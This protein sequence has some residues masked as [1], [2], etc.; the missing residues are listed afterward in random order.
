MSKKK[1]EDWIVLDEIAKRDR[2]KALM[3][4]MRVVERDLIQLRK[5]DEVLTT[6][7][8]D[9]EEDRMQGIAARDD[10]AGVSSQL[11]EGGSSSTGRSTA[12]SGGKN[13]VSFQAHIASLQLENRTL[14][15]DVHT[16]QERVTYLAEKQGLGSAQIDEMISQ[17][18]A[19][20][21]KLEEIKKEISDVRIH[22]QE[23]IALH[24]GAYVVA[25]VAVVVGLLS[26]VNQSSETFG[27]VLLLCYFFF[28]LMTFS[29]L[30]LAAR[31]KIQ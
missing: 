23:E 3:Q 20:L 26:C 30:S 12:R 11:G 9:L 29:F 14:R 21:A 31:N 6:A 2:V 10:S 4:E 7:I 1:N 28:F 8:E 19:P 16:F 24:E 15:R 25:A 22:E 5:G 18:A 13:P 17:S 27:I